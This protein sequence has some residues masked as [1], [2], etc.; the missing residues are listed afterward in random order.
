MSEIATGS[1]LD[2][3]TASTTPF[4]L[5]F[6]AEFGD[7]SQ[8]VCMALAAR[9]SHWPVLAGTSIAFM[10]LNALAVV[11][12]AGL[13]RWVP[14]QFLAVTVAVM[15]TL[16]GL[17]MLLVKADETHDEIT[18]RSGAGIFVAAFLMI[19][20]AEMGDKTQIAVAAMASTLSVIPVWIGATLALMATSFLGIIAGR[21]LLRRISLLRFHQIAGVF[22]LILAVFAFNKAF[23]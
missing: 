22:F 23:E 12:G 10:L 14:Q 21:S 7:K 13:A 8:L 6:F 9:H 4:G 3:I 2:W 20:L 18:E 19:F 5:V 11:F 17:W 1:T 15:F 16:F